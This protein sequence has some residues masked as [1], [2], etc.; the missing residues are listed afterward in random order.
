MASAA[1]DELTIRLREGGDDVSEITALLHRAYKP[2]A[3]RGMRYVA[4][5]QDDAITLRRIARGECY[6]ALSA[7][8]LVGTI[9]FAD[10]ERTTGSLWYDRPDVASFHQFAVEP[11]LQGIG[12]GGR[13]LD[14]VEARAAATGAAEIALDT[15]EHASSLIDWYKRRGYRFVE[16]ADWEATNYR[17]VILS[18]KLPD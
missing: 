7:G 17:S 8:R 16:Y 2:L 3:D 5:W 1:G 18:R 4:S 10:T 12:I 15:S 6:V 13:L 14:T 11:E 9:L